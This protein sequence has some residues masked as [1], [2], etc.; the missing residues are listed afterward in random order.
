MGEFDL[1]HGCAASPQLK[2]F[3]NMVG[4]YSFTMS[5]EDE[6]ARKEEKE[7]DGQRTRKR[8]KGSEVG[9]KNG[10][11]EGKRPDLYLLCFQIYW[12]APVDWREECNWAGKDITV[13]LSLTIP[14][15]IL[16]NPGKIDCIF[17][18]R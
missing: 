2:L 16:A 14:Y 1:G 11:P 10:E 4:S 9:Q 17:Y 18:Y 13:S 15:L 8:K 6:G 5:K 7:A 12:P 3:L